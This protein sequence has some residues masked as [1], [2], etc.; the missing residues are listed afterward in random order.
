MHY[1]VLGKIVLTNRGLQHPTKQTSD[2]ILDVTYMFN[3]AL[4]GELELTRHESIQ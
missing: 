3:Y 1:S 2:S 4:S